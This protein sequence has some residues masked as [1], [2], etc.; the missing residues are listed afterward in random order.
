M[1]ASGVPEF[2]FRSGDSLL[3]YVRFAITANLDRFKNAGHEFPLTKNNDLPGQLS[4]PFYPILPEKTEG[5]SKQLE[6]TVRLMLCLHDE[7]HF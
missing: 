2:R 5:I 3:N 7:T 1:V 4:L 6:R